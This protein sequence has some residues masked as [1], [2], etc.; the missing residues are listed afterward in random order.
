MTWV[1]LCE[2]L[3]AWAGSWSLGGVQISLVLPSSGG[4]RITAA[5]S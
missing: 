3:S 5:V 1:C 2:T 4:S